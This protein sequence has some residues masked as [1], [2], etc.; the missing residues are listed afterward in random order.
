[1]Q[2]HIQ[3]VTAPDGVGLAVSTVGAGP[4]LIIIPGW[5]SH[6]ELDWAYPLG[7]DFYQRLA[8]DNLLVRYDKRGTGLSD[9]GVT[10]YSP[11]ANLRD[12]EAIITALG[13]KRPALMGYSQ[14]GP[15]SVA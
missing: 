9:R 5:I 7:R 8:E 3:F 14:G 15:I 10:D 12:L 1:M 13:L 11:E 2:Q 4:P 6:L